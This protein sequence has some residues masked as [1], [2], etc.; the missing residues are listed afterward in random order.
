MDLPIQVLTSVLSLYLCIVHIQFVRFQFIRNIHIKCS[1]YDNHSIYYDITK[2]MNWKWQIEKYKSTKLTNVSPLIIYTGI[3]IIPYLYSNDNNI[4]IN[5]WAISKG[6][7]MS[8]R[9]CFIHYS[10]LTGD[11][12]TQSAR[13]MRIFKTKSV[14]SC[15]VSELAT[16]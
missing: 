9:L 12:N 1:H 16:R 5:S 11:F 2:I 8:H 6:T 15:K 14:P 13:R 3:K 4:T 10:I 7:P